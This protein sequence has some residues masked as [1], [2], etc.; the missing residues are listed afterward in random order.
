VLLRA[1]TLEAGPMPDSPPTSVLLPTVEWTD[2][3]AEVAAQLGPGDDLL[4]VHDGPADPVADRADE[5]PDGVRLV[6]A[7]EPE[8]CSGKANAIAVGMERARHDRLVW[9]DDDFHHPPGWL[10]GLHTDYERHG[11]VS[12]LPAFVGRDPLSLLLE[13]VYVSGTYSVYASEKAWGGGVMFERGDLDE[14]AFLADLRRT[15][16]DDGLLSEYLDVTPLKRTR[17]VPVGG[18]V[19]TTLERQARFAHIVHR[20]EP[21]A[22]LAT[23]ALTAAVAA[24]C[25]LYPTVLVPLVTLSYAAIYATFGVRR[26]T[27]LLGVPATLAWVP[28][29]AYGLARRTFVWG[30][31]RYRWRSKFDVEVV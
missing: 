4:V 18:S 31:R 14:D 2:A 29:F 17:E 19:R 5:L 27:F 26:W 9:T 23:N 24:G 12:E 11:P 10:D 22:T 8:G 20:H 13:P 7:G 16:S 28:M 30:G 21:L 25:V 1:W 15:V 3:C 6:A